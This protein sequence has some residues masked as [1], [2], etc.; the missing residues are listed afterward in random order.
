M[1]RA[2]S[3]TG[4]DARVA[5]RR[6]AAV[7]LGGARRPS[8]AGR[9]ASRMVLS[10][11]AQRPRRAR[12]S[13]AARASRPRVA[14]SRVGRVAGPR[15]GL[16]EGRAVQRP[17]RAAD[18]RDQAMPDGAQQLAGGCLG[19]QVREHRVDR[20]EADHEVVAVVAVAEDRIEAGQ[21]GGMPLDDDPAAP[22]RGADAAAS[23][24]SRPGRGDGDGAA[25]LTVGDESR[26]RPPG[27]NGRVDAG[28]DPADPSSHLL[29]R[30]A[31]FLM[32]SGGG[33]TA[34]QPGATPGATKGGAIGGPGPGLP[35]RHA[36]RRPARD[37]RPGR[38]RDVPVATAG[39]TEDGRLGTS[40]PRIAAA[41]RAVLEPAP[42]TRSSCST[43]AARP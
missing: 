25:A 33:C 40:A 9:S 30:V 3:A 29:M 27:G 43:S 39:G 37:G 10:P 32:N 6:A 42:T 12:P 14:P 15:A 26:W 31:F 18:R 11:T 1:E 17:G 16:Q 22:Q 5:P 23:M 28:R 13:A 2:P 34:R 21:V 41:I 24:R 20:P 38:R 8:A 36:R 7:A 19:R 35:Q 4:P